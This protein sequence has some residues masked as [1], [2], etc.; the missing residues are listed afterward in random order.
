MSS[1]MQGGLAEARSGGTILAYERA[2]TR[3]NNGHYNKM[4][5]FSQSFRDVTCPIYISTLVT[6]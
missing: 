1:K 5:F 4:L 6:T 2:V 3:V